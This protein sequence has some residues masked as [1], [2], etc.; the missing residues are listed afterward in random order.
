MV[1]ILLA[2]LLQ[3]GGGDAG[4]AAALVALGQAQARPLAVQPV[5]LV[6]LVGLAGLELGCR[7]R[8]RTR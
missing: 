5:G 1:V 6:G 8:P 4:L 3:L 2:Q 7:G